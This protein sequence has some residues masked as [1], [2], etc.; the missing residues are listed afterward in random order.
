MN[1]ASSSTSASP[2]TA[3]GASVNQAHSGESAGET[4]G[5]GSSNGEPPSGHSPSGNHGP[6][7]SAHSRTEQSGPAKGRYTK[8]EQE[9]ASTEVTEVAPGVLRMQLP[10]HMPGLGHVNCYA[11]CDASGVTLVDPGLPGEASWDALMNRL[12]QA[13]IPL[14]RVHTTIVTHSHPD[15]YGGS[16]QLREETGTELVAH[17]A[18]V[19]SRAADFANDEIDMDLLELDPDE[20]VELWKNKLADL[21]TTPWG[22]PRQPPPDEAIRLWITT[23]NHRSASK[24]RVPTPTVNVS[25][26]TVLKLADR[27]WFAVHTPGHTVD[28]LCLWDPT[29]GVLLS[30]DHV[31]PTIT[32]HIAGSTEIADP[33]AAFFDSLSLVG[34]FEGLSVCLPAHG[35]PFTGLKART[36]AIHRHHIERLDILR[37]AG[38]NL[39]NAPVEAYMKVLFSPRA[40]GDMAASETFAH[41]EH[42]RV[43]GEAK[44]HRDSSGLLRFQVGADAFR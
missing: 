12:K 2:G 25:H 30:G 14:K 36:E 31:L 13:D 11:L 7:G 15:H 20:L 44:S 27:D 34:D 8:Q 4:S 19:A 39:V 33:L 17:S 23:D 32:P 40:W 28:H 21:G 6:H 9:P 10:V 37:A 26:G 43:I 5:G 18:F 1:E 24:F 41:L 38:P 42:L 35:H 22:T 16:H 29:E 3:S